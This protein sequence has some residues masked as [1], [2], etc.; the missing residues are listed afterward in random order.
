MARY[1]LLLPEI[2]YPAIA[3]QLGVSEAAV[4]T[5]TCSG[6]S[7]MVWMIGSS[8]ADPALSLTSW[9][10]APRPAGGSLA[11]G[12]GLGSRGFWRTQ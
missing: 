11:N 3:E 4:R 12:L 2:D 7:G 1:L 10:T 6:M 5:K 8:N 9:K